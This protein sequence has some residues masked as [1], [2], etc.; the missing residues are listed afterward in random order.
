[1]GKYGSDLSY[2]WA[3]FPVGAFGFKLNLII[4]K[5]ELKKPV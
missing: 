5:A 3:L 2:R 1:M 4:H